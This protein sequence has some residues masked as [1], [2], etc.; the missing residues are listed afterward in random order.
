MKFKPIFVAVTLAF[1]LGSSAYSFPYPP[2][3]QHIINKAK[4]DREKKWR[5]EW[6]IKWSLSKT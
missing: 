2:H 5:A 6:V 4:A 1:G 3:H